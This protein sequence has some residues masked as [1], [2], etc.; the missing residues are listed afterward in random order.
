MSRA[1]R[2]RRPCARGDV[3]CAEP[4]RSR[5]RPDAMS[6]RLGKATSRTPSM[7]VDEKSDEATVPRKRPNK[8]RSWR[9]GSHPRETA[10]R[11]PWFGHRLIL[12]ARQSKHRPHC[13]GFTEP[14]GYVDGGAIDQR[15]HG[16]DTG[17]R[18]Q[19]PSSFRTMASRRRCRMTNCVILEVRNPRWPINVIGMHR[20]VIKV[21]WAPAEAT[22]R[23]SFVL[24]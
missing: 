19:A 7:H 6:G 20:T 3:L 2:S 22:S 8:G 23:S 10:D 15:H 11:R 13:L 9:E 5:P 24:R 4:G 21:S 14:S 1:S 16:A 17:G 12:G 18:H